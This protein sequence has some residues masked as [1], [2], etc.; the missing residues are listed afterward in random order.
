MTIV[1]EY[2]LYPVALESNSLKKA[3]KSKSE[4]SFFP[5]SIHCEKAQPT[6]ALLKARQ[7]L[8]QARKSV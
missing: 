3:T 4:F 7:A 2:D 5:Y 6:E 8:S 1:A